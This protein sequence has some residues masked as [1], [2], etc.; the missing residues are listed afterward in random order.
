MDFLRNES[1]VHSD[2]IC[3]DSYECALMSIPFMITQIDRLIGLAIGLLINRH[4][5]LIGDR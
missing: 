4:I 2:Q 3:T 5:L 1:I